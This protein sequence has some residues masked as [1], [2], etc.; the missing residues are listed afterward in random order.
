MKTPSSAPKAN[1]APTLLLVH[2]FRGSHIGLSD[3]ARELSKL[4]Y[5]V[6]VPDLPPWGNAGSLPEYT[7][8]TY[9]TYLANYI[10]AQN[11]Q[12][13]LLVGQSMGTLVCLALAERE[14]DLIDDRIVLVA[15]A[16]S[17]PSR[18]IASLTPLLTFLP[19]KLIGYISTVYLKVNHSKKLFKHTLDITY[20]CAAKDSGRKQV[21][22]ASKFSTDYAL[23]DFKPPQSKKL[24]LITGDHDRIFSLAATKACHKHFAKT[25][26]VCELD[27]V[28]NS[29]HLINCE[30]PAETAA[31]AKAFI[32]KHK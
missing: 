21:Y 31:L 12:K 23:T 6:E 20:R 2:G 13:P 22:K 26:Q 30:K 18:F 16:S 32:E 27:L 19:K 15:P 1:S 10:K 11:L 17:K 4:G 28:E 8:E 29:G 14:P 7:P 3:L 25:H 5:A 24:L 9:A